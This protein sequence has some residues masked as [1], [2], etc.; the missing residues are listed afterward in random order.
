MKLQI[1][2]DEY[3]NHLFENNIRGGISSVMGDRY[4]ESYENE[5]ILYI[6]ANNCY[7]Y[8]VSEYLPYDKI[9]SWRSHPELYLNQLEDT[10]NTPGGSDF[11][12]FSES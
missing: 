11:G 2:Q 8:A 10:L 7:R 4:V 6:E 3:F 9:E 1:H 5:K 12:Y